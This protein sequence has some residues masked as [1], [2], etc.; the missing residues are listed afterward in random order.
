MW[1]WIIIGLVILGLL[2]VMSLGNVQDRDHEGK[3]TKWWNRQ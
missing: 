3:T 2:V 1:T